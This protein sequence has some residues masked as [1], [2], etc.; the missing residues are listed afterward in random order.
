MRRDFTCYCADCAYWD[1]DNHECVHPEAGNT[2]HTTN[3]ER[4]WCKHGEERD[5]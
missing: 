4:T 5:E 2:A 1:A 3:P